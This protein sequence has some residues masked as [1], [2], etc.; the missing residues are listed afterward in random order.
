MLTKR[1]QMHFPLISLSQYWVLVQLEYLSS[2][3]KS[4]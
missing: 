3:Y 1:E 4:A 2:F